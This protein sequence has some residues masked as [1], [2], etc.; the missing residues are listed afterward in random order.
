[1][2]AIAMTLLALDLRVPELGGNPG[3]AMLRHALADN[4]NSYLSYLISFYVVAGYWVG[5][6][7]ILRSVVGSHPRLVQHTLLLLLLVAALPFPSSLLGRYG[8]DVP[9]ALALYGAVNAV[10]TLVLLLLSWDVRRLGLSDGTAD[11]VA[12]DD[13]RWAS[14]VVFLLCIPAAYLL[15]GHGPWVLVLL[16]VARRWAPSWRQARPRP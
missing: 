6:R 7:R 1:V 9:I 15:G 16:L 11:L 8:G 14:L 5:H 10:A 2:F 3:D 13:A 4:V 12:A